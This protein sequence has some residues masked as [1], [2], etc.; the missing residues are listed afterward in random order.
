[1]FISLRYD[2][3]LY[4]QPAPITILYGCDKKPLFDLWVPTEHT[5][6]T[7]TTH[8][9]Y[10]VQNCSSHT[11]IIFILNSYLSSIADLMVWALSR[12]GWWMIFQY[13]G[14]RYFCQLLL[15]RC[16]R[17]TAV[18]TARRRGRGHQRPA[19][20]CNNQQQH[21]HCN[22]N[23]QIVSSFGRSPYPYSILAKLNQYRYV[24][25]KPFSF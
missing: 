7:G 13:D 6:N 12:E 8:S 17:L 11:D 5:E 24:F 21:W 4:L 2:C 3:A 23:L 20:A 22:F 1:M 18:T 19:A 14:R 15:P 10:G 9:D 16:W 25:K